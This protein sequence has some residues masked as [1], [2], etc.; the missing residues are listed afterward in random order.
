MRLVVAASW[1]HAHRGEG[2]RNNVVPLKDAAMKGKKEATEEIKDP[3]EMK[4][5]KARHANLALSFPNI[6]RGIK[7]ILLHRP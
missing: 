5:Y 3:V 4:N 6:I 7:C 2:N 1:K